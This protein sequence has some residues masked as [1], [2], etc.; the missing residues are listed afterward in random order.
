MKVVREL[1]RRTHRKQRC[2]S[3]VELLDDGSVRK[4]YTG[5]T[6]WPR[7]RWKREVDVL[8]K[9]GDC[10]VTPQLLSTHEGRNALRVEYRG[11][12]AEPSFEAWNGALTA[13]DE[14]H[15]DFGFIHNDLW[16]PNIVT[17]G[18]M[19]TLVDLYSLERRW[20]AWGKRRFLQFLVEPLLHTTGTPEARVGPKAAPQAD[21]IAGLG[22]S[23]VYLEGREPWPRARGLLQRR[24]QLVA[25][26]AKLAKVKHVIGPGERP[27]VLIAGLHHD[28]LRDWGRRFGLDAVLV[29]GAGRRQGFLRTGLTPGD[30][31]QGDP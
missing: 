12:P 16:W 1:H 18:R 25:R 14:L 24:P 6:S 2:T 29:G 26:M 4:R 15:E 11:E 10:V 28:D 17:D 3:I 9:L 31:D 7:K 30:E 19:V 20:T 27:G 23:W 22:K 21:R 8:T 5:P 13:W